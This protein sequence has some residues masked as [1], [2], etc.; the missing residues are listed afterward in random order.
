M[1]YANV[2]SGLGALHGIHLRYLRWREGLDL[3]CGNATLD[4]EVQVLRRTLKEKELRGRSHRL[5]QR[6]LKQQPRFRSATKRLHI[7]SE[8]K[9]F[10]SVSRVPP[11]SPTRRSLR[12]GG[13]AGRRQS[14]KGKAQWAEETGDQETRRQGDGETTQCGTPRGYPNEQETERRGDEATGR[15]QATGRMIN[16]QVFL[17]RADERKKAMT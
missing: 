17:S 1:R 7:I 15:Q 12:P 9:A 4:V 6:E 2:F 8:L 16:K 10:D 3:R 13:A 14:A 5:C 11:R